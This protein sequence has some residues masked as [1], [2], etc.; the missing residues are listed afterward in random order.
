MTKNNLFEI[1]SPIAKTLF[2][3]NWNI[4]NFSSKIC[5]NTHYTI[6]SLCFSSVDSP[7][8]Q[9][10]AYLRT[11]A[12]YGPTKASKLHCTCSHETQNTTKVFQA[13]HKNC[14][15]FTTMSDKT[16]FRI[17][18]ACE[19]YWCKR[20]ANWQRSA[21]ERIA[22]KQTPLISTAVVFLGN[23]STA[24]PWRRLS[25]RYGVYVTWWNWINC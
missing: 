23:G 1:S 3:R 11:K 9:S 21:I 7:I 22:V 12:V 15:L 8:L 17:L 2:P 4:G 24:W 10:I 18:A 14:N 5:C 16:S 19:S 25:C 6:S 20:L 13:A